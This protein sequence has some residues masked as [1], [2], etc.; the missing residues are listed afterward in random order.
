MGRRLAQ[1]LAPRA[2]AAQAQAFGPEQRLGPPG[3]KATHSPGP[4][5]RSQELEPEPGC[6]W[7]SVQKG[8]QASECR[9]VARG[10]RGSQ[11][12]R[13]RPAWA[14]AAMGACESLS[15]CARQAM[16]GLGKS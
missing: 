8:L 6:V 7:P 11:R 15:V 5:P 9:Q 16:V 1:T 13:Q 12:W 3:A 14:F 2:L 10:R 4:E